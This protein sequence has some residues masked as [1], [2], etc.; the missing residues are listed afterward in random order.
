M[1]AKLHSC[2]HAKTKVHFKLTPPGPYQ[3]KQT[4]KQT[5]KNNNIN[6]IN[7]F[8][9]DL[10]LSATSKVVLFHMTSFAIVLDHVPDN[11]NKNY[12]AQHIFC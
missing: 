2:F 4:N 9:F 3:N 11:L 5:N 7:Y 8:A 12:F 1:W 6:T 10:K